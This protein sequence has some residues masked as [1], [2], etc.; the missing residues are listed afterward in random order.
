MKISEAAK[1][2]SDLSKT[3]D[4]IPPQSRAIKLQTFQLW[5]LGANSVLPPAPCAKHDRNI[6]K[7]PRLCVPL[8]LVVST[9]ILRKEFFSA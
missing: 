7:I 6:C 1:F 2:E 3:N 8:N 4:D 5:G 9:A